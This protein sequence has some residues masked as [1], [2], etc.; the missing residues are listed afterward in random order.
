LIIISNPLY[1]KQNAAKGALS[2]AAFLLKTSTVPDFGIYP[3]V[4]YF[5]AIIGKRSAI[6]YT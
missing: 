3:I 4:R 2:D 6:E 5:S 1:I